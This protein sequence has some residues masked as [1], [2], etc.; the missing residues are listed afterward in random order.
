MTIQE[1]ADKKIKLVRRPMWA[2]GKHIVL[3]F[4]PYGNLAMWGM[5]IETGQPKRR[6][7]VVGIDDEDFEAV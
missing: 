1:C 5:L 7:D 6:I 2:D 4:D 3:D